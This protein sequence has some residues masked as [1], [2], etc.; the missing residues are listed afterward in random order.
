LVSNLSC[1]G[2]RVGAIKH[3][4]HKDFKVDKEGTN[5]WRY[6]RAG[7]KVTTAVSANEIVMIKKTKAEFND[8]NQV[9]GLLENEQLDVIV[10]E[11][12]QSL[13]EKREDVLKII[14][15]EDEYNLTNVLERTV[16]PIIAIAGII[17]KQKPKSKQKIPV[18][19]IPS[20]GERL[21]KTVKEH[22]KAKGN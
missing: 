19:N 6:T 5:T 18:I 17:G 4:Y 10:V 22:L 20:E 13:V 1:E 21:L 2:Y 15:A 7:A 8:L 16:Q 14:T 9:I 12:F 11:G 3:I